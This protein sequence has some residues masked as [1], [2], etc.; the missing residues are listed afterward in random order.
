[1]TLSEMTIEFW[2]PHTKRPRLVIAEDSRT[3]AEILVQ[4]GSSSTIDTYGLKK[5]IRNVFLLL[6]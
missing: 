3:D 2:I 6:R 4:D 1:M 5:T